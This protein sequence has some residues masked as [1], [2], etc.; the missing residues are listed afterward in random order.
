M[1]ALSGIFDLEIS[2]GALRHHLMVMLGIV[3]YAADELYS[4]G[5]ECAPQLKSTR[6]T[7]AVNGSKT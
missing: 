1:P 3:A 2:A 5:V 6:N 7:Q 4:D